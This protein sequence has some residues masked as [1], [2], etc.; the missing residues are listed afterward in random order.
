MNIQS[1]NNTIKS[2]RTDPDSKTDEPMNDTNVNTTGVNDAADSKT[3][4]R[5]NVTDEGRVRPPPSPSFSLPSTPVI[6]SFLPSSSSASDSLPSESLEFPETPFSGVGREGSQ[7]LF[8]PSSLEG[9][10]QS[11]TPTFGVQTN[12]SFDVLSPGSDVDVESIVSEISDISEIS[13]TK[14]IKT[15]SLIE[16]IADIKGSKK[17]LEKCYDFCPDFKILIKSLSKLRRTDLVDS[18]AKNRI[19]KLIANLQKQVRGQ[20]IASS[21]HGV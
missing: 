1:V 14:E 15:T 8:D 12:N 21:Q 3:S 6:P 5:D 13:E 2:K 16:F 4:D 20:K 7:D 18:R 19:L 10:T 11:D 17:P 9:Q